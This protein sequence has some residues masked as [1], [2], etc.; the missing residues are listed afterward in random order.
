MHMTPLTSVLTFDDEPAVPDL[1]SQRG[2]SIGRR[3]QTASKADEALAAKGLQ[4]DLVT[5]VR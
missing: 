1:M 3:P 2:A 4:H 5:D